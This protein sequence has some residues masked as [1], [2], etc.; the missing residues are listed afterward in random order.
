MSFIN[1]EELRQYIDV[2]I[3]A[4]GRNQITGTVMNTALNGLLQL[5]ESRQGK[6]I[7]VQDFP[8]PPSIKQRIP[9][10]LWLQPL[11]G[12]LH[13]IDET[14]V[15]LNIQ[16]PKPS[17]FGNPWA[18]GNALYSQPMQHLDVA[19][20]GMAEV[21]S[22]Y[23]I[24]GSSVASLFYNLKEFLAQR[25]SMKD[26]ATNAYIISDNP[27]EKT[28]LL[29]AWYK[30]FAGAAFYY[31]PSLPL[32]ERFN[33]ALACTQ[34]EQEQPQLIAPVG[35]LHTAL[36]KKLFAGLLMIFVN[37]IKDFKEHPAADTESMELFS[38]SNSDRSMCISMISSYIDRMAAAVG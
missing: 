13:V 34:L 3:H 25:L 23:A 31:D 33:V 12:L 20:G 35:F 5:A 32:V 37:G 1:S 7:F 30:T 4:N 21:F 16:L 17:I 28:A 15:W 27:G 8:T 18:T 26:P 10:S 2:N 14:G 24:P 29:Q 11:K 6:G 19:M 36:G 22:N 38:D 9:G